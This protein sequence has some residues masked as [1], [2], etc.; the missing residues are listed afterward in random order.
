[1]DHHW[2][3]WLWLHR[4]ACLGQ[5]NTVTTI[6][7]PQRVVNELPKA[8]T[9]DVGNPLINIIRPMGM[10]TLLPSSHSQVLYRFIT[11]LHSRW[12]AV[13]N[14]LPAQ[15]ND[16]EVMDCSVKHMTP[17]KAVIVVLKCSRPADFRMRDVIYRYTESATRTTGKL[18]S[19]LANSF[20]L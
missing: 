5:N 2:R 4:V 16:I 3:Q 7:Y 11:S 14:Q 10:V 13:R 18:L 1:M 8:K 6:R 20:Q 19:Q 17:T 12:H 9:V 15:A